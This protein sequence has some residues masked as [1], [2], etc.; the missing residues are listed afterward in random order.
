V[1]LLFFFAKSAA[2]IIEESPPIKV[3]IIDLKKIPA[4]KSEPGGGGGG[5]PAPAPAPKPE[6]PKAAGPKMAAPKPAPRSKAPKVVARP[7]PAVPAPS[8]I[9]EV[10]KGD[11]GAHR[12]TRG[13]GVRGAS[14]VGGGS[15]LSVPRNGGSPGHRPLADRTE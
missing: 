10:G 12:N 1:R 14:G 9:S 8:P 15:L 5:A 3:T 6:A 7:A 11:N 4:F 2:P 13:E